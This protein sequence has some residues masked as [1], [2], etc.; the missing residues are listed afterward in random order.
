MEYWI[1]RFESEL[2][3]KLSQKSSSYV[4]NEALLL[5]AFK[6]FDL[7]DSGAVDFEEWKKAL[8]KIGIVLPPPPVCYEIFQYY[9]S[10]NSGSLDYKEFSTQITRHRSVYNKPLSIP[11]AESAE[12]LLQSLR[13]FLA[14]KASLNLFSLAQNFYTLSPRSPNIPFSVFS[15]AFFDLKSPLTPVQL[16]FLFKYFNKNKQ[17][18]I[19]YIEI[20]SEIRGELSESRKAI[21]KTVY[22][23]LVKSSQSIELNK[24]R[25]LFIPGAHP[26]VI[27]GKKTEEEIL[28]VFLQGLEI[29]HTIW[30][31]NND[32][33]SLEEFLEYYSNISFLIESDKYFEKILEN[34]WKQLN[35]AK[36]QCLKYSQVSQKKFNPRLENGIPKGF[37]SVFNKFK[38][39]LV[40]RGAKGVVGIQ[41]E[42]RIMDEDNS[43]T[44]TLGEFK[45]GCLGFGLKLQDSEVVRLFNGIDR[46]RNGVIDYLEFLRVVRGPMNEFRK[47][48]VRGAWDGLAKDDNGMANLRDIGSAFDAR[49]HPD[50][51]NGRRSVAE[52]INEFL[53]TFENHHNISDLAQPGGKVTFEEFLDY[54][55]GISMM[56]D[57]DLQFEIIMKNSWKIVENHEKVPE[58]FEIPF[59]GQRKIIKI[60]GPPFDVSNEKTEYLTASNR[61]LSTI[62][63]NNFLDTFGSNYQKSRKRFTQ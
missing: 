55:E 8:Q 44:L 41:R 11:L 22:N 30:G 7:D 21:I 33:V 35:N 48:I 5:K 13:S 43:R 46:D 2:A 40:S 62:F 57:N 1:N 54:Y 19:N 20:L 61:F 28:S 3:L 26:D 56:I 51:K 58:K 50:V 59:A 47:K 42:F 6:Y 23:N 9:D 10:D 53:E 31:E 39:Q 60:E 17:N 25:K 49:G 24:L 38:K 52:I 63:K 34:T 36:T 4:S 32:E 37:E 27:S 12:K 18:T 29:N 15:K 14:T 16:T 45:K